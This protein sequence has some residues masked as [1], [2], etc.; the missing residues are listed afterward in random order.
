MEVV[1]LSKQHSILNPILAEIRDKEM[2]KDRMRFRRNVQRC[3]E[4]LAYEISKGLKYELKNIVTPLGVAPVPVLSEQPIVGAI[5]R[6]GLVLHQGML[7]IF[8]HADNA[9]IS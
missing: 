8:D 5:L 2:Q 9:F 1:D 3:G 4:I 6:A 7:N